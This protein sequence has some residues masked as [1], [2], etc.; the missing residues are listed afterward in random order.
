MQFA[1]RA[2]LHLARTSMSV[3][4]CVF[5]QNKRTSKLLRIVPNR[6]YV[7]PIILSTKSTMTKESKTEQ[8]D[9]MGGRYGG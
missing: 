1:I 5:K 6:L 8:D 4:D 2:Q 7:H 3:H 9:F